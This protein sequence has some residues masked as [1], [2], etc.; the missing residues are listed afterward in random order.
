[1]NTGECWGVGQ[2][3]VTEW[4]IIV[5]TGECLDVETGVCYGMDNN[6]EYR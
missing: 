6:C 5:N 1:M 4:T 3:S 2:V